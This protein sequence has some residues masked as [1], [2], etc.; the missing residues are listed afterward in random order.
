MTDTAIGAPTRPAAL[1][2]PLDP[3]PVRSTKAAAVLAL[4]IA[5]VITGPLVGGVVPAALGL[6]LARQA[7]DDLVASR[8]YLTGARHVR[9]GRTLAWVGI[10]LA[11]SALVA[12]SVV[13]ILSLAAGT[14]HDFPDTSN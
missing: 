13:G 8:G 5:A 9:L 12:A 1:R 2:H 14:G 6:V 7:G 4:G 10:A 3:E 11:V